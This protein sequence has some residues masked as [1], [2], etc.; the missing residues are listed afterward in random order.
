MF[1]LQLLTAIKKMLTHGKRESAT[2]I[3]SILSGEFMS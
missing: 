3:R 1:V 2:L